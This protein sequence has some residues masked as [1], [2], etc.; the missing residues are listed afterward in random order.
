MRVS[1][2]Q[3]A[4]SSKRLGVQRVRTRVFVFICLLLAVLL[5]TVS[6]HAQQA[7]IFR[8]GFL[9]DSTA[10]GSAVL[11]EVFWQEMRKLGWV[12]GKNI[13]IEY[14]FAEGKYNRLPDL[15]ADLVRQKIDLIVV[16]GGPAARAA[17]GA[18]GAIPIVMVNISDPVGQGFVASLARPE[19][20]V[21]GLS[22]L[23][24]EL[25]TKRL[26]VLKDALPNLARVGVLWPTGFSASSPQL[27]ELRPAAVALKLK[28]EEIETEPDAKG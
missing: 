16:S 12:E 4:V 15:A 5:P 28:L 19:G 9:D 14:R 3:E 1:S 21:T 17:K 20:N 7:Q 25:G 6:L 24:G 26:E 22:F 11:L 27:K 13:A 8:I 23:A 10:S 18:T 2:E